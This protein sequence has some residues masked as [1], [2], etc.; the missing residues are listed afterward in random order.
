[1]A[2]IFQP[3]DLAP[4]LASRG[5]R[6]IAIAI[7]YALNTGFIVLMA[8]NFGER[9]TPEGGGIGY[10]VSGLPAVACLAFWFFI[11]PVM[12]SI[13]GQSV[14][15]MIMQIK[16]VKQDGAKANLINTTARHLL[17]IVDFLP[18]FGIVGMML[19]SRSKLS[20]R[21]GDIFARTIV[22]RK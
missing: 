1:M 12:E 10:H 7:D 22:V 3:E 21:A 16:V 20:Q 2:E 6:Y 11:M 14:G 9:Y 15:K 5:S 19:S 13:N 17:D 4:S 18:F 8:I